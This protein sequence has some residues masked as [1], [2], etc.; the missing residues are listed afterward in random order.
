MQE[1]NNEYFDNLDSKEDFDDSITITEKVN[2]ACK[3]DEDEIF[4]AAVDGL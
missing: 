1:E 2:G 4:A 3:K